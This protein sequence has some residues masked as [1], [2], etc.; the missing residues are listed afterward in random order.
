MAVAKVSG[1]GSVCIGS[2][3]IGLCT[4]RVCA[5]ACD[6]TQVSY[7]T[8]AG[9]D[10]GFF[11]L[12]EDGSVINFQTLPDG[13]PSFGG[14]AITPAFNYV[15]QGA[16]FSPAFPNLFISGNS[17]FGYALTAYTSNPGANNLITAQLTNP[18]R[19]VGV[20]VGNQK[21]LFA[22]DSEGTL[23]TSVSHFAPG[24]VF[25]LGV[26]SIIPIARVVVSSGSNS[27]TIDN[28]TMIHIP[29]PEPASAVQLL[30]AAPVLIRRR[31]LR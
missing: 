28:F 10:S 4:I 7:C 26:K 5:D 9:N 18:E 17:Q 24:E 6:L 29:V 27:N 30:L 31:R 23:I 8:W 13:T 15:L 21:S 2:M 1:I 19:G 12:G 16:L 22:Y 14:A 20:W 3:L 25:F 11:N